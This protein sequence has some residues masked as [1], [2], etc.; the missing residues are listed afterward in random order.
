MMLGSFGCMATVLT[1]I[2]IRADEMFCHFH[3]VPP[4][5]LVQRKTCPGLPGVALEEPLNPT[6]RWLGSVGCTATLV[7]LRLGKSIPPAA[8]PT[9]MSFQWPRDCPLSSLRQIVPL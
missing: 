9:V 7:A 1:G 6:T 4:S 8:V 2:S 3:V 5:A